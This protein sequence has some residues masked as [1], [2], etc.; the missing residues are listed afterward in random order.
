MIYCF[1]E[2]LHINLQ[3]TFHFIERQNFETNAYSKK[4]QYFSDDEII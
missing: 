4:L 1:L 2:E 3:N